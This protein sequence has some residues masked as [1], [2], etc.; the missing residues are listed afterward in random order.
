ML[1][2]L[3]RQ[4]VCRKLSVRTF[5][6]VEALSRFFVVL[7]YS[8]SVQQLGSCNGYGVSDGPAALLHPVTV[9]Q[10]KCW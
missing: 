7:D 9:G 5:A 10:A 1:R 6:R 4:A 8:W 2:R 3:H